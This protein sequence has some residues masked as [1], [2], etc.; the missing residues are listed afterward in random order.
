MNKEKITKAIK[1]IPLFPILFAIL[2][3]FSVCFMIFKENNN[4][5]SSNANPPKVVFV[6]DYKIGDGDWIEYDIDNH[7]PIKKS[8]DVTLKGHFLLVDPSS[9]EVYPVSKGFM[10]AFYLNHIN[11]WQIITGTIIKFC[12]IYR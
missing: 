9:K 8:E 5:Q 10:I 4:V 3:I 11:G 1:K 2:L 6:G 7:I 12:F